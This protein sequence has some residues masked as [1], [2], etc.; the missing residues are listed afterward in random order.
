M[1]F[2]LLPVK[3]PQQAKQRLNGLLT[4]PQREGLARALYEEML[5]KLCAARG[6]DRIAVITSDEPTARQASRSGAL[7]FEELEQMGHSQSADAA[8]RRALELGAR[9][10]ILLP[11]D[12]PLATPAE[13]EELVVEARRHSLLIVPSEDGTGTNALARTPPDLIP[14]C[15]GPGSFL[16][17]L[18]QARA[19]G[20]AARVMRLPGLMFDV[21]TPADLAELV[22]RAPDSRIAQLVQPQ[23]A[24]SLQG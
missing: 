5:A 14:S 22:R 21:D 1:I 11:I 13:I 4:G 20:V 16:A 2:A 17:H 6:L 7:V 9:T 18:E 3:A 24:S 15:F 8:A 10:V 23:W 19:R 12:V